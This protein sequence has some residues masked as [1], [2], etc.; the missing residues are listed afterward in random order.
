LTTSAF[1]IHPDGD[2]SAGVLTCKS[3]QCGTWFPI[4]R[5]V[6]RLLPPEL[7]GDLTQAFVAAFEPQLIALGLTTKRRHVVADPLESVKRHT[8]ANFGFEWI[9]YSRFGWDDPVYHQEYE[10]EIFCRK[11]LLAPAELTGR[12]VLDAGCGNGRYT[13]WAAQCGARVFG[14]DLGDGVESAEAN[15]RMLSNV[16][17]VQG[18]ILNVP[19]APGTFDV[20]FSIGVL[21]H[22]GDARRATHALAEKLKPGSSLT[23]HVYGKGNLIYETIDRCLRRYTTRLSISSLQRLTRRAFR[24]RQ[25]LERLHLI[26]LADRFVRLG[27]HPHIIFDWYAAP[28][29]THHT[30]DEVRQW[31]EQCGLTV[32]VTNQN[33]NR[34]YFMKRL[35]RPLMGGQTAVTMKGIA[36]Y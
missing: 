18:D 29:A 31:F 3:T 20:I 35:L 22:T 32:D 36:R 25:W 14:L 8:I 10:R 11:S 1:E 4:V 24:V 2:I 6:P 23:V 26:G 33:P 15:T 17:I 19:F 28:V 16:Q 30:H 13:Y 34:G 7:L 21:M 27:P 9:E 5:R 12:I